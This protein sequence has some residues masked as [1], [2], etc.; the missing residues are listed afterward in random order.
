MESYR[1][2]RMDIE[3]LTQKIDAKQL[4]E[5]AK[6][7]GIKT[8]CVKKIDIAKQLPKEVLERLVSQAK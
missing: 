1:G 3:E 4:K 6:K 2:G 5:E 8:A 7:R